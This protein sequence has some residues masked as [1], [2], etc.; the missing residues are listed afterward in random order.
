M[1]AS[2]SPLP[3][4][5]PGTA[6]APEKPLDLKPGDLVEV[7]SP[8]EIEATLDETGLNRRLSFDREM[9]PYCG[10][11]LPRQG[12]GG[13]A[14]RRPH[15]KMLNISADCL[16]LDDVVCSGERS[17]GCW[18]C[19]RQIYPYWREAW[20]RRADGPEAQAPASEADAPTAR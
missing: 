13:A 14:H 7:R 16:I 20:L 5:G 10:K 18:F 12:P 9:L 3:L 15:R 6:V 17:V 4:H 2:S 8:S 11:Y 1:S 19:P